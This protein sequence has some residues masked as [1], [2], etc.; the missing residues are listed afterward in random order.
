[1]SKKDKIKISVKE[2]Y[3]VLDMFKKLERIGMELNEVPSAF[4]P[5]V[6]AFRNRF[7]RFKNS[8]KRKPGRMRDPDEARRQDFASG[9][10]RHE[11]EER[12]IR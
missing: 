3:W 10:A 8:E 7:K 5:E 12:Q 2:A 9:Q 6:K 11:R 4:K 1:M